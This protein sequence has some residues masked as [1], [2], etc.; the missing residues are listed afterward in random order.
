MENCS[1]SF[2]DENGKLSERVSGRYHLTHVQTF[3]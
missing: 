1:E 3:N 2:N